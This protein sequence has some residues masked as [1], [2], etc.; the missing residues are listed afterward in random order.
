MLKIRHLI[1]SHQK[2]GS[3]LTNER[4]LYRSIRSISKISKIYEMKLRYT[5]SLVLEV[6]FACSDSVAAVL[7]PPPNYPVVSGVNVG[8]D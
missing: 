4:L 8:D 5:G 3:Q 1:K 7:S 6:K 2:E